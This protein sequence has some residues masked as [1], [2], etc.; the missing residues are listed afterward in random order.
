MAKKKET[1]MNVTDDH[2]DAVWQTSHHHHS[3]SDSA[4]TPDVTLLNKVKLRDQRINF[5]TDTW[6]ITYWLQKAYTCR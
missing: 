4:Y 1:N 3:W 6:I 5:Q 2:T